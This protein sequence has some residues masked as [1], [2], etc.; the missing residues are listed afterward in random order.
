M[1]DLMGNFEGSVTQFF[2]PDLEVVVFFGFI[3]KLQYPEAKEDDFYIMVC[4]N[5]IYE[6]DSNPEEYRISLYEPKYVYDSDKLPEDIRDIVID[7]IIKNY[8]EGIKAINEH[9][10]YEVVDPNKPIPDYN[11]L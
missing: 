2:V 1:E 5:F 8:S 10:E 3:N 11:K 6:S 4:T 7:N 9:C